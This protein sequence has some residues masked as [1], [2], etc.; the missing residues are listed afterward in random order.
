VAS[1]GTCGTKARWSDD[2]LTALLTDEKGSWLAHLRVEQWHADQQLSHELAWVASWLDPETESP[3]LLSAAVERPA[4]AADTPA[5]RRELIAGAAK[6]MAAPPGVPAPFAAPAPTPRDADEWATH[7]ELQLDCWSAAFDELMEACRDTGP[8][9]DYLRYRRLTQSLEWA[10]AIDCALGVLWNSLPGAERERAS[11]ITDE[12]A[13]KAAAHNA[14][15][16]LPFEVETDPA[17]A[18]YIRRLEDSQPYSHWGELMLAGIF[19]ARF[20]QALS[21]VRGQLVHAATAAPMDLRQFRAGAEPRWKWRESEFF[22]RGRPTDVGR[23]AYDWVLA[24]RDVIGLLSHLTE[25]FFE[26]Q[27]RLRS[28]LRQ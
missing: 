28:H 27:M 13:R 4:L 5:R 23:R 20:F 15:G 7:L 14:M 12:H 18:G 19:Q 8:A 17:F 2:G 9:A 11:R 22:S 10:Y 1:P 6:A 25:L 26:A 16:E 21:W 3:T 24:G